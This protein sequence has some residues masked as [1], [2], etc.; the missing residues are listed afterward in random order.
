[1]KEKIFYV[2]N[3]D[4]KRIFLLS[5]FLIGL[6]FSFF[7]LGVSIGRKRGQVQENLA[8]ATSISSE[9]SSGGSTLNA[10]P[11]D[12]FESKSENTNSVNV[13]NSTNRE[14]EIRFRNLPPNSEIV[15]L[16]V[17]T[18][19][20]ETETKES[21]KKVVSDTIKRPQKE[22]KSVR[23]AK[24]H[25]SAETATKGKK[26]I[27]SE[28]FFVQVAAFKSKS[29]ADELKSSLGGKSFVKKTANGYFTVRMGNFSSKEEADRSIKRLPTQLKEGAIISK[30]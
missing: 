8:L 24:D 9:Q 11:L 15:D 29:K 5:L 12:S 1:M 10:I 6:L 3:L 25:K 4:N 30:E 17:E 16:K 7:F 20:K 23:K 18:T 27:S 19:K 21:E 28:N 26:H 14:E 22:K 13:A 2:I